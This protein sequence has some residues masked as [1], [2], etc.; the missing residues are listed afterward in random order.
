MTCSP[1]AGPRRGT[2]AAALGGSRSVGSSMA[3]LLF[4]LVTQVASLAEMSAADPK[5][6]SGT[7]SCGGAAAGWGRRGRGGERG[8]RPL[9]ERPPGGAAPALAPFA[10]ARGR[11]ALRWRLPGGR[12]WVSAV[13]TPRFP[14]ILVEATKQ[15]SQFFSS[16]HL[17]LMCGFLGQ[18]L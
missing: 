18:H 14:L 5:L 4:V 11:R 10:D 2:T 1:G 17:C 7:V 6:S 12:L 8:S 3:L 13:C 16:S 15:D 9:R